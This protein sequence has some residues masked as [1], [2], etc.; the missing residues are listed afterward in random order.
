M[1]NPGLVLIGLL[2]SGPC[3]TVNWPSFTGIGPRKSIFSSPSLLNFLSVVFSLFYHFCFRKS[4]GQRWQDVKDLCYR[5]GILIMQFQQKWMK[6]IL[7]NWQL[8]AA[9][10]SS[11]FTQKVTSICSTNEWQGRRY[12]PFALV[13]STGIRKIRALRIYSWLTLNSDEIANWSS[14]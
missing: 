4:Y 12:L 6:V 7:L 5:K 3:I 10:I 9:Q 2:G 11:I 8:Q 14:K 13:I 1:I